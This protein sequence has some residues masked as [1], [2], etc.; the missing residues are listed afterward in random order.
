LNVTALRSG[1]SIHVHGAHRVC[2][3]IALSQKNVILAPAC[4]MRGRAPAGIQSFEN[5]LDAGSHPA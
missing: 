4:V 2:I 1:L 5:L 3:L